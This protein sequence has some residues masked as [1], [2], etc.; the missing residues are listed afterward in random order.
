M[1]LKVYSTKGLKG[2]DAQLNRTDVAALNLLIKLHNDSRA[3]AWS[4]EA[5]DDL[6]QCITLVAAE[7]G[8][9]PP[10]Y[11]GE[12]E[13]GEGDVR[14]VRREYMKERAREKLGWVKP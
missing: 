4:A 13:L 9:P 6:K 7:L 8:W 5:T 12:P 10:M 1:K 3:R 2:Q 11:R 14:R